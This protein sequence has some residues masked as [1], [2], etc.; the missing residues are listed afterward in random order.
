M[1]IKWDD[2]M[3]VG[4]EN[5]DTQHKKL[6][7]HLNKLIE[8]IATESEVMAVRETLDFLK[9][10]VDEHFTYEEKYMKEYDYPSFEEHKKVHQGF[11]EFLQ[12]FREDFEAVYSEGEAVSVKLEA[13]AEKA[14]K[15]LGEWF[16]KHILGDDMGYRSY[17]SSK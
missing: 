14:Q 3:S 2:R 16:V 4:E 5:I 9:K 13:L 17:I 6:L 8:N 11:I 10:Y 1:K 7:T 12:E 15:F